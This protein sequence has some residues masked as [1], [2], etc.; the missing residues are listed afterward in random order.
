MTADKQVQDHLYLFNRMILLQKL[1]TT[2]K[3]PLHV[4]TDANDLF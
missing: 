1:Q 2:V 3:D 4:L